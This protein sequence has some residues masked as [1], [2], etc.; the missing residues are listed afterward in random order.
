MAFVRGTNQRDVFVRVEGLEELQAQFDRM[1]KIPKTAMTKAAKAGMNPI[2]AD[3]KAAAPVGKTGFLKRGVK[4]I[5]E[6]PR[7]RNKSVYFINWW[8]K[9]SD[10]Y[11]KPIERVGLYG[12][13]NQTGYYPQSMEWGFKTKHGKK[14]GKYFVRDAI[15]KHQAESL[16]KVISVLTDELEKLT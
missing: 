14:A 13:K 8:K 10:E 16:N 15:A 11:R 12:G 4:A 3:A 9:Y 5:Q 6:T 2:V 1:S 7:K